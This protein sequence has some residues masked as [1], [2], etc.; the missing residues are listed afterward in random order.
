MG[1]VELAVRAI[2]GQQI[3]VRAATTVAGRVASMFGAPVAGG[4][5]LDRLFPTPEQLA[6]APLERAG[7][8]PA[9]ASTVR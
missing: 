6:D 7:L 5:A 2:I 9:R 8:M 1:S 3:S 4:G